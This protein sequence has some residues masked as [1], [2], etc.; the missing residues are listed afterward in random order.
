LPPASSVGS[1]EAVVAGFLEN[2]PEAVATVSGWVREVVSH[3]AWGLDS[4][5]DLVQATLLALVCNFRAGRFAGGD[6]R[7]YVRRI[8]KN[9]CVSSY[10]RRRTRGREIPWDVA[11]GGEELAVPDPRPEADAERRVRLERVLGSLGEKCR[12]LIGRAYVEGWSR[13]EIADDLGISEGA[14][15]ARLFRCLERARELFFGNGET[16]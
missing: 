13:R 7:A 5:D 4:P 9:L 1:G 12:R 14:A 8:A 2:G 11:G 6:L 10:R 15:R 3:R 16:T